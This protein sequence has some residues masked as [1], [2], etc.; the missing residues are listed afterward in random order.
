[1]LSWAFNRC[2]RQPF[3]RDRHYFRTDTLARDQLMDFMLFMLGI[4]LVAVIC[5]A[6]S[7]VTA[8]KQPRTPA[9]KSR[10][11]QYFESKYTGHT[12][13]THKRE[14][15]SISIKECQTLVHASEGVLFISLDEAGE[16][17]SL[18]FYNMYALVMTPRQL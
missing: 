8:W 4:V 11:R 6:G 1:M 13:F 7:I 17:R 12:A 9:V 5:A 16:R 15:Q 14:L 18:P 2:R 10:P 3:W